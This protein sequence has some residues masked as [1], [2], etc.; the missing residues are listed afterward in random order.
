MII[1]LLSFV[2]ACHSSGL[3]S[4]NVEL[5]E[6]TTPEFD[7][8]GEP[9]F[10][11][12]TSPMD[13]G[14]NEERLMTLDIE[15]VGHFEL[16]P[17]SGSFDEGNYYTAAFGQMTVTEVIDNEDELPWCSYTFNLTGIRIDEKCDTC[18]IAFEV[19]FYVQENEQEEEQPQNDDMMDEMPLQARTVDDCLTPDMPEHLESRRLGYSKAEDTIYFDYYNSGFWMPW[20]E[21]INVHN[22]IEFSWESTVG[23]FGFSDD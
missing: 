18:D 1:N 14:F 5:P 21:T 13:T 20:Y 10:E 4:G 17:L 3:D 16:T 15:H 19:Q 23:F 22:R 8:T 2:W 9:F 12:D 7:D 11:E 6:D